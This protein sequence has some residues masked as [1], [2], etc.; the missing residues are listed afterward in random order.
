[1]VI[2]VRRAIGRGRRVVALDVRDGRCP[3]AACFRPDRIAHE[4]SRATAGWC[5]GTRA[6]WGCPA[7]VTVADPPRFR[8]RARAWES[9]F[10]PR[11]DATKV[12]ATKT[13]TSRDPKP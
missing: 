6:R 4:T 1:M 10:L 3:R 5:C 2:S 9:V 8:R 12:S 7:E 11:P 13:N